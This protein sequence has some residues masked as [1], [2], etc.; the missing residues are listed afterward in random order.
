MTYHANVLN[1]GEI[2]K[3]GNSKTDFSVN[4]KLHQLTTKN[5]EYA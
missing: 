4:K 1:I 3:L 5:K 2:P